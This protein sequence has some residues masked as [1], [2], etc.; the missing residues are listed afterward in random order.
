MELSLLNIPKNKIEQL[1]R[2]R[3][4]S[5]E[6]LLSLYP[7][8]YVDRSRLTG[9]D[10]NLPE[11][12]FLFHCKSVRFVNT[13]TS[14]VIADGF[15]VSSQLPVQVKWFNHTW[16][17]DEIKESTRQDI[18]VAGA[19]NLNTYDGKYEVTN[20]AVYDPEGMNALGLYPVYRKIPG[21]AQDYL[22]DC[23]VK[24]ANILGPP[25]EIVPNWYLMRFSLIS[26]ADMVY[27][28]HWPTDEASLQA[29]Q[30]R[31]LMN[32]LMYFAL[33]VELNYRGVASG[34]PFA[35]PSLAATT[36]IREGLPFE[37][38]PDQAYAVETIIADM[39]L[40]R[41]VN[42]LVQGDVGSGKTI[43][44]FLLMLAVAENGYQA[45]L[46]APT[47]I[48]AKQHYEELARLVEPY[49]IK[50]AFVSGQKLRKAEQEALEKQIS[51]GEA[52]L[53]VGTQALL[54]DTY[55]FKDLALVVED[56]EHKYGVLQRQTL[57]DKA[58]KG[59][60]I[61]TMSATPI[62]R[63]LALT[64]YGDN[65][66][67]YSIKTKP[68]GRK[69]VITGVQNKMDPVFRYLYSEIKRKGHQAYVVCPLVYASDKIP[70]V[71]SVEETF[72]MYRKAL[73]S[74]EIRV[75]MVTGKTKKTEAEQTIQKFSRNEISILI[76]TTVIEVG[77][78][79]PNATCIVI[80]NAERFGL[81]QL[82]QLRGRVGRGSDQAC[83]VLYSQETDNPRLEAMC[84]TSDGFK[85][86][87]I[88]LNLRGAGNLLGSE[89]SGTEKLLDLA[90]RHP[91]EY[92]N[93]QDCAKELFDR[94]LT[95]K[96]MEQ[97]MADQK[98]FVGGEML[99]GD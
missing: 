15:E 37:L 40:G 13:K 66:Q 84:L 44:A 10:M 23:I 28:L 96:L 41:R 71:T 8:K 69:P 43:V 68:A 7:R 81:A 5:L 18:L 82:H 91:K 29:A 76:S 78:N 54:T 17:F 90:L 79:V 58:A 9:I 42:A 92:R 59:T 74:H 24:A 36:A 64:I 56:E 67:V 60:H 61:V 87:E 73:E 47:Q 72:E 98:N 80:Q 35:L 94:G 27:Q 57:I 49:G 95:C 97:A 34:S 21:M 85:I 4:N 55:Q 63:T 62:P 11:S 53:I 26:Y 46:M 45:A 14:I 99:S 22:Q 1:R 16:G 25:E 86:A 31:K 50:V 39:R 38:T 88:D 30:K 12:V 48:L 51:S 19:V 2:G 65:V 33:R 75:G 93:A 6:D 32:D 83:C 77:V 20:P 89:Q 70:G 52:R 3:I